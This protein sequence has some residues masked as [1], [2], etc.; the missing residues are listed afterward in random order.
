VK[1]LIRAFLALAVVLFAAWPGTATT[2]SVKTADYNVELSDSGS[3]ILMSSASNLTVYLPS[4]N[5]DQIGFEITIAKHGAGNVTVQAHKADYIADGTVG[6]YIR[7]T[8]AGETYASVKLILA[9]RYYWKVEA[10]HGTWATPSSTSY[11]GVGTGSSPTFTGLTLSGLTASKPVFTNSSKALVSTGTMPVDQGGTGIAS[12][13][14]GDILYASGTTTLSQL[15]KGTANQIQGMNAGATGPEYKTLA[16]TANQV[17]VTHGVGSVTLSAPQDLATTSS[18]A[19]VTAKFSDLTDGYIPY[20]VSDASGL[21]NSGL[22]WDGTNLGLGTTGPSY[23]FSVSDGTDQLGLTHDGTDAYFKTTDGSF[24]FQTDEG[25]HTATV[26]SIYGKGNGVGFL[27]IYEEDD[28]E[29]LEIWAYSNWGYIQ[30]SGPAKGG[31]AIN[32]DYAIPVYLWSSIT[33]GNPEFRVYGWDAGLSAVRYG[34]ISVDAAGATTIAS[35]SGEDLVLNPS[36]G[37]VGVGTTTF[38]TNAVKVLAI[39][40][41]TAP[42]TSPADECQLWVEDVG[43]AGQAELRVRD[44]LGNVTTLSPHRF[45]LFQ[46]KSDYVLP[47]SYY[48]ENAYIGKAINVDMYGAIAEVERLSGKKF[49]YT[50][51]IKKSSWDDNQEQN[52]RD[53]EAQIDAANARIAAL[54]AKIAELGARIAADP[55]G[56]SAK[57]LKNERTESISE[58]AGTKVPN[59]YEKRR[60]PKWIKDRIR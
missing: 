47:W 46:P 37:N 13:T 49:I 59:K 41:G 25:T 34:S 2:V 40:S 22:Y 15:A 16:G 30:T 3:V 33:S 56:E 8:T 7:N 52:G 54:E 60:P 29:Y 11:F 53:R 20:H 10:A 1:R 39:G 14:A 21:A 43:G 45:E 5:T 12:Y 17:T 26:V 18:P 44:E 31:L 28:A 58:K 48:S 32:P 55:E 6:G 57:A 50:A 35:Q 9:A 4:L 24:I 23:K 51:D 36:G 38:G 19:Y 27:R 42:S